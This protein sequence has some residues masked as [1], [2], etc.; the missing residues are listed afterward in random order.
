[1]KQ[2]TEP[3]PTAPDHPLVHVYLHDLDVALRR[4]PRDR[5]RELREQIRSHLAETVTPDADTEHAADALRRLGTPAQLVA[6]ALALAPPRTPAQRLR[7]GLARVRWYGWAAIAAVIAVTAYVI[8][9]LN[10]APLWGPGGSVWWYPQDRVR[11]VM[12]S[13]GD[14]QQTAVPV[15]SGQWQG[16]A[17]TVTNP[18]RFTQTILGPASDAGSPNG[19]FFQIGVAT[20]DPWHGGGFP[21]RLHYTLPGIIP[22][23]Q[24]RW[25]RMLW[26][27]RICMDKGGSG[28]IDS[29]PVR[30]RVGLIT[31]TEVIPLGMFWFLSGPSQPSTPTNS[32]G[33]CR[34]VPGH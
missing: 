6:Q 3:Q 12:T 26:I 5:A 11:E 25:V 19:P 21:N 17:F 23:H 32:T 4:L 8:V 33:T 1:V 13:A 28:G 34:G 29:L 14:A 16:F 30:V 24:I 27:S 22:P 31:R 18:S 10:A 9:M 2:Q 15:R 20:S 7:S